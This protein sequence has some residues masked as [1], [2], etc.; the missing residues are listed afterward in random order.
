MKTPLF[1]RKQSGGMFAVVN[2]TLTTGDIFFVDSGSATGADSAGYGRN[3]DSPF[4]TLAYAVGKCAD[5]NGDMIF[6]MPGHAEAPVVTIT[7]DK[8]GISIIGIGNSSNRPTFT[9]AHTISA[10]D[11]FDVTAANVTIKNIVI[12]TGTNTGGNSVQLNVNAADFVMENCVIQMG[13]KNLIGV[14]VPGG[15]HRF[16]FKDCLFLGTAAN[17][18]CAIDLEGTGKHNNFVIDNCFFNFD[19]SSGLDEAAVRSSKTDTGILIKDCIMVGMDATALDF[20]SSATGLVKNVSVGS[21]NATVAEL[22]DV[23]LLRCVDVRVAYQS[24]SGARIPA[25]TA[26]P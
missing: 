20:N 8:T 17:P 14:T 11:A 25:T 16:T 13:A 7:I 5:A 18:D 9:P 6:L 19:G 2:E 26:T 4:L 22:I 10:D 23:G 21:N 24:T 15:I 3:P 1:V 12:A